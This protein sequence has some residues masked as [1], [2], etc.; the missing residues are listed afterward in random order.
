MLRF[1]AA[2]KAAPYVHPKLASPHRGYRGR[3]RSRRPSAP[4]RAITPRALLRPLGQRQSARGEGCSTSAFLQIAA[5]RVQGRLGQLSPGA[6]STSRD[7]GP[8]GGWNLLVGWCPKTTLGGHDESSPPT[9]FATGC[10]RY[11]AAGFDAGRG[12]TSLSD[13]AGAAAS[14]P[15]SQRGCCAPRSAWRTGQR[16][17]LLPEKFR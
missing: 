2:C 10:G 5:F 16:A 15:L 4:G 14:R 3:R 13:A 6:D 11:R 17:S 1:D 9:I 7:E 12:G 8:R